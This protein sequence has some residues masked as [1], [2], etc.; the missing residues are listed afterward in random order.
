MGEVRNGKDKCALPGNA[1]KSCAKCGEKFEPTEGKKS[2]TGALAVLIV[3][4]G[5]G[6]ALFAASFGFSSGRASFFLGIGV[7]IVVTV[8][9][10]HLQIRGWRQRATTCQKCLS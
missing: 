2:I 5:G 1:N 3:I 4:W 8:G 10:W 9:I 7:P 6:A